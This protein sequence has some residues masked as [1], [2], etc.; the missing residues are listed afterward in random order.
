M[1]PQELLFIC[2]VLAIDDCI[3]IKLLL[4][5]VWFSKNNTIYLKLSAYPHLS[6]II[7]FGVSY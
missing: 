6:M 7:S 4:I 5:K 3:K 2:F 1:L